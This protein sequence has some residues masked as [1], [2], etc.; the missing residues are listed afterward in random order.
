MFWIKKI[1][2]MGIPLYISA[3]QIEYKMLLK[4]DGIHYMITISS[5][6]HPRCALRKH[7]HVIY[8]DF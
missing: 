2:K 7:V 5:P 8:R 1:K 3:L 6:G 4:A